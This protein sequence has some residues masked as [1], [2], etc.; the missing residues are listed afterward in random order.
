MKKFKKNEKSS[1]VITT[2]MLL[3]TILN[4]ITHAILLQSF[5]F[6]LILS[7]QEH[8]DRQASRNKRPLSSFFSPI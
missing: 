2:A 5:S 6:T 7:L 3:L 1:T 8:A 4:Q